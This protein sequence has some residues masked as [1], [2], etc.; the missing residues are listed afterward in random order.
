MNPHHRK[1]KLQQN[2]FTISHVHFTITNIPLPIFIM[3]SLALF[4]EKEGKIRRAAEGERARGKR[5]KTFK[6]GKR[7]LHKMQEGDRT[8]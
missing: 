4:P 1:K 2:Y 7:L 5:G 6:K 8:L 3:I